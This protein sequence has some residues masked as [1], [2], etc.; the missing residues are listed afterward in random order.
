MAARAEQQ[1]GAPAAEAQKE[2]EEPQRGHQA[3]KNSAANLEATDP[4]LLAYREH[5]ATAARISLAEE[6]RTLV[7]LGGF[8]VLATQ[9]RGELDGYPSGSVVEYAADAQVGP[10]CCVPTREGAPPARVPRR[11]ARL[12]RLLRRS[13][14]AAC[15]PLPL[16]SAGAPHLCLLHHEPPHR[17]H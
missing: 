10:W 8:G 11:S 13:P 7:A 4:E 15:T 14:T 6:A 1:A 16:L 3:P 2:E 12:L 5:Q 17:R 9:A